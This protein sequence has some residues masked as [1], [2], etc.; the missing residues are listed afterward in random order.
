MDLDASTASDGT[1]MTTSGSPACAN[2]P[3]APATASCQACLKTIC[4]LCLVLDG[5]RVLCLVCARAARR[6]RGATYTVVALLAAGGL[7]GA[8]VLSAK[9]ESASA[10]GANDFANS[11]IGTGTHGSVIDAIDQRLA[12]EPCD[13]QQMLSLTDALARAG[14]HRAVI[15]RADA[16]WKKCG[17]FPRLRWATYEAHKRLSELDKAIADASLLIADSPQDKDYWWWRGIVYEETGQLEKAAADFQQTI[18]IEPRITGIPFNLADV[19]EKLGKPCDAIFPIEQFLRYHPDVV[20]RERVQ[21]RLMRLYGDPACASMAGPGRAVIRFRPGDASINATVKIGRARGTFIVDT[22]A[23]LTVISRQLADKLGLSPSKP[24]VVHTAGG[25]TEARLAMVDA[26]EVQGVRARRIPVAVLD[27]LPEGA[28]GL[29]G[30]SFLAR[31]SLQL[32][33]QT[34]KLTIAAR[35][36]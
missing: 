8:L 35:T 2:H 21:Q 30:L 26:M 16:F 33:T 13:R 18:T 19:Y 14:D 15:D 11:M 5:S 28:D 10:S 22:G 32:E 7:G 20:D 9:H 17:P 27:S 4:T 6:R 24:I 29:L 25:V 12:K 31:F 36:K 23:S 1:P 34:G 3:D